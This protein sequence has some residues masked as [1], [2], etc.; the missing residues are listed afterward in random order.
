MLFWKGTYGCALVFL[1]SIRPLCVAVGAAGDKSAAQNC[2]FVDNLTNEPPSRYMAVIHKNYLL[3]TI[4]H[5]PLR[6][7]M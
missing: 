7:V 4:L 6:T 1:C 3:W 5:L 2:H